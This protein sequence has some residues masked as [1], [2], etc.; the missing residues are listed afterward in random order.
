LEELLGGPEDSVLA[1]AEK[2]G[3]HPEDPPAI[4]GKSGTFHVRNGKFKPQVT[5][6]KQYRSFS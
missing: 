1:G 5:T 2:S 6:T 3:E 4:N